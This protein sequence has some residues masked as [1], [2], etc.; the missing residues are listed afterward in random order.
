MIL[1]KTIIVAF[2]FLFIGFTHI[3]GQSMSPFRNSLTPFLFPPTIVIPTHAPTPTIDPTI[4]A[5]TP[6]AVPS[7]PIAQ[8]TGMDLFLFIILSLVYIMVIHFALGI[9]DEFNLFLMV[10]YFIHAGV[11]GWWF[12][13]FEAGFIF[14]IVFTLLFI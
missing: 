10:F 6:T 7:I 8:A 4:A 14:G 11:I 5:L 3:K 12:H 2:I 1:I 9:G 13:N